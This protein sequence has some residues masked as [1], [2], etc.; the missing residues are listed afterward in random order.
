M[1]L[2]LALCQYKSDKGD[3]NANLNKI[4]AVISQTRS[5]VY[6]FPELFLTGHGADYASLSSDV[7]YAIDKMRLWCVEKDIAILVGSPSYSA[8]GMR[9][10]ALFITPREVVKYD[11]LYLTRFDT[12]AEKAFVR[13]DRPIVSK[14]KDITFGFSICYD[15]FFP[16]IFRNYALAC[17]DVNISIAASSAPYRQLFERVLPA[18]SLENLLYTVFVNGSGGEGDHRLWGS[19]RLIGPMGNTLSDLDEEEGVLCVY[20]DKEVVKNARKDRRHLEDRRIDIAWIPDEHES[21]D[22]ECDPIK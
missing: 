20:V 22:K 1:G 2:R 21:F 10:S 9:N 4:M 11:Q 18:R 6:I 7:Q 16:E 12:R 15:I 19:S 3:V 13:G 17:S 14:F 8:N 5:D